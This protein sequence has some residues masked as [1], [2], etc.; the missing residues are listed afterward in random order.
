MSENILIYR[1]IGEYVRICRLGLKKGQE[2]IAK[3]AG[4]SRAT[5][6]AIEHDA[7][8]SSFGVILK[9]LRYLEKLG[10]PPV[11]FSRLQIR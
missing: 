11:D 6:G 5:I 9:I 2:D 4:V 3:A 10:A 1:T 8:D 7:Q